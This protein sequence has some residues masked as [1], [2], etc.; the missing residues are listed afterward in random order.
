ML[1]PCGLTVSLDSDMQFVNGANANV[2][3]CGQTFE[4]S[5]E[6]HS[7]ASRVERRG[8]EAIGPPAPQIVPTKH[9][10]LAC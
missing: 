5:R 7:G 6:R 9:M 1:Q 4:V 3:L 8:S 2:P 10:A